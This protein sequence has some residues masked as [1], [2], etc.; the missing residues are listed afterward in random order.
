MIL[1]QK[2]NANNVA[3][4]RL[5]KPFYENDAFKCIASDFRIKIYW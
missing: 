2:G 1:P 5:R 4:G 3:I